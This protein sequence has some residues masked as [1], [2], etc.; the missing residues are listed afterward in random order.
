MLR[1]HCISSEAS[2]DANTA[3]EAQRLWL[4]RWATEVLMHST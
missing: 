1:R 4:V 3:Y 2:A